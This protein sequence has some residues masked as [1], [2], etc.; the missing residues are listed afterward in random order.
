MREDRRWD[1]LVPKA[2]AKLKSAARRAIAQARS[3]G[4]R[5]SR[6]G[7][8]LS[9]ILTDDATMKSLNRD[10]RGKNK[11]TN[12]LSFAALDA[13]K[14]DVET[15]WLLGDVVLASGVIE[16]EAIE[17]GKAVADHLSHMAVHGV[18]HL[19]GYDHERTKE[20][21]IMEAIEIAALSRLGIGNPYI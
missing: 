5:G 15:P 7:H 19:L 21:E 3:S 13:G 8:E 20:A 4:W 6:I 12:V 16:R 11:P 10:Y 18:L 17:Q 9:F 14:P 2:G 1:Q